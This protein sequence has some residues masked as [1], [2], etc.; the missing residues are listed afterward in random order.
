M[1]IVFS[2]KRIAFHTAANFCETTEDYS[3]W[4]C[5]QIFVLWYERKKC[6][7]IYSKD[8]ITSNKS[9]LFP[10]R[11]GEEVDLVFGWLASYGILRSSKYVLT[12]SNLC[13]TESLSI[14]GIAARACG[15]GKLFLSEAL[16]DNTWGP[17]HYLFCERLLEPHSFLKTYRTNFIS[18]AMLN[19]FSN[20]SDGSAASY[21][22]PSKGER[23]VLVNHV[24]DL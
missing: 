13:C 1:L 18:D 6:L 9:A 15:I 12:R 8:F 4:R 3:L 10:A 2:L 20:E 11:R 23:M 19:F 5:K 7:Q 14:D 16:M 24:D 17:K 21:R 22:G